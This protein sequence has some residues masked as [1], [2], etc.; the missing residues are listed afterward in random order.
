MIFLNLLICLVLRNVQM[1][2]DV[3]SQSVK[4]AFEF[5][6][7]YPKQCPSWRL[8]SRTVM[9]SSAQQTQIS[10]RL[11]SKYA[12][13]QLYARFH[14]ICFAEIYEAEQGPIIFKWIDWYVDVWHVH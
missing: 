10:E 7:A 6:A 9:V 5:P 13:M 2:F 1:R 3:G 14:T 4:I 8:I 11:T 12:R